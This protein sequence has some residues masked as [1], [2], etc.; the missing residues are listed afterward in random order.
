MSKLRFSG[1]IAVVTGAGS[2]IGKTTA[3]NFMAE[4]A[5]VFCVDVNA[6][7]L[8]AAFHDCSHQAT[9]FALDVTDES[10][11]E[12]LANQ[13]ID[14][15]GKWDILVHSAGISAGA[16]LPEMAFS[17]WRRVLGVNLDGAFLATKYAIRSMKTRGGNIVH[18]SS[19]S[20]IKPAP[21]AVAYSVS[22]AG[23]C[24]LAKTAAKECK[25]NGWPIRVNTVCPAGVKTPLW[26]SMPFFQE[27][28][29]QMGSEDAAFAKLSNDTGGEFATPDEIASMIMF[30]CSD[31]SKFITGIDLVADSGYTL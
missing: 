11:W 21:G 6:S 27:L 18:V 29:S 12:R 2:G 30:L 5:H 28:S 15:Y 19:A 14:G 22:K 16:S 8:D 10:A 24:M 20:G 25:N 3:I 13:V 4:G 1:K 17:E 23:M 9:T 26:T 7:A 31:E